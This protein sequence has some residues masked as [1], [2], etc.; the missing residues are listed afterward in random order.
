MLPPKW[1][2]KSLLYTSLNKTESGAKPNLVWLVQPTEGVGFVVRQWLPL[3]QC[4]VHGPQQ[5]LEDA[6][7]KGTGDGADAEWGHQAET[8]REGASKKW[9][10]KGVFWE[11]LLVSVPSMRKY[12]IT[13]KK[14]ECGRY[15]SI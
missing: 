10:A 12:Q 11:L 9:L 6:E 1:K 5:L 14:E 2:R 8:T 4:W 3:V 15:E 7:E 13:F